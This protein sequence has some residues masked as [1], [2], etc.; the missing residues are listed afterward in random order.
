MKIAQFQ[1]EVQEF[2]YNVIS[3]DTV[4]GIIDIGTGL[5]E[6]INKLTGSFHELSIVIV[7]VG[8]AIVKNKLFNNKNGGGRAKICVV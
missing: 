4:K 6:F 5:L 1:N 8:A 2:W 3:S 7:G